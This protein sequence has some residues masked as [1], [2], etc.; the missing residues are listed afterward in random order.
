MPNF[1]YFSISLVKSLSNTKWACSGSSPC[2]IGLILTF[3]IF[4]TSLYSPTHPT[5][6]VF[7]GFVWSNCQIASEKRI[8]GLICQITKCWMIHL[9][10]GPWINDKVE[11]IF[12][13]F[14]FRF[15]IQKIRNI[16]FSNTNFYHIHLHFICGKLTK[17]KVLYDGLIWKIIYQVDL[18]SIQKFWVFQFEIWFDLK[19]K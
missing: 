18:N 6:S 11:L 12:K 9:C 2:P 13:S 8:F 5:M 19:A 14:K 3:Q 17:I 4:D 1:G 10:A 7:P 16:L 15:L